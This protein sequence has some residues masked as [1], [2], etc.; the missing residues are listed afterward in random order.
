[1]V[2]EFNIHNRLNNNSTRALIEMR[3]VSMIE[4][5]SMLG[6]TKIYM[7]AVS[8][9][10]VV[11]SEYSEVKALFTNESPI[12]TEINDSTTDVVFVGINKFTLKVDGNGIQNDILRIFVNANFDLGKENV[13]DAI[14]EVDGVE[15]FLMYSGK[16]NGCIYVGVL[17]DVNDV[18]VKVKNRL[19][20]LIN[21]VYGS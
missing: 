19:I 8:D 15:S 5:G 21:S 3:N 9:P 10:I 14:N 20:E 4:S 11:M 17:F 1:M 12:D 7:V 18:V 16:Y 2:R 6:Q 13:I